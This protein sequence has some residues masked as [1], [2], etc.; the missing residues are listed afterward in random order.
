MEVMIGY[1]RHI[2]PG[3]EEDDFRS[4][5]V[6]IQEGIEASRDKGWIRN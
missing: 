3:N 4:S 5:R 1:G 6:L 2:R